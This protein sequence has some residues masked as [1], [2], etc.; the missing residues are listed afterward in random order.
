QEDGAEDFEE[1]KIIFGEDEE[2]RSR[3]YILN[4]VQKRILQDLQD[5]E[6]NV[7]YQ[8]SAHTGKVFQWLMSL[9]ARNHVGTES[10]FKLLFNSLQDIV[11]KTEDDRPKRLQMLKDRRAEIDKEI[12]AIELGVAPDNY[13]N[14]Q[15]QERLELFTRLCYDL[16]SD[17]REVEDNFKQIHRAIVEQHTKAEQNKG[18]IV[19]FAFAAYDALRNSNQ[20]KS[21]YAFWDFLIS[22]AGQQDWKE[23]TEQL[24]DLLKDRGIQADD[25]FL[26]NIKSLLLE[27][28][29]TVYDANDKM[30]E[31]L[32]RIISEKEIARHKR[33]RHQI[34]NIKELIFD[35]MEDEEVKAGISIDEGVEIRMLMERRLLFEQ[36][37]DKVMVKQ[38]VA[39]SEKIADPERFSRMV[40]TTHIDKKRLWQKV[41]NTLKEKQT[42]TLKEVLEQQ[43]LENGIAEIVSYFSFLRDK[44]NRVQVIHNTSEHI[45]LNEAATKF[46]EVPYLLFSK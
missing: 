14:S 46:V 10:R 40:S 18:A 19:G 44:A 34:G 35:L 41:E 8:L 6:G 30:A 22:R 2:T 21:F 29:K 31:K 28:G 38:P 16:I 7:Q 26:Q 23:L 5:A 37:K 20:G 39:A 1:A 42:A 17:F 36:K 11:E 27:Q 32:S 24:V 15:V 13:S 45:P 9:Q 12:K 4:W 43:P 33:L 3:K 25:Q